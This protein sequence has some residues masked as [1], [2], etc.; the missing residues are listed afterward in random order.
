M[1]IWIRPSSEN[2]QC[3]SLALQKFGFP[4][5]QVPTTL[6]TCLGNIVRLGV[7]PLRLEIINRISGVGFEEAFSARH[8]ATVDGVLVQLIS[9]EHLKANKAAAGRTKDQLDLENL[10]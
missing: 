2:A 10:P 8:E 9:L 6:F 3:V 1:D 5:D 4:S 7:P